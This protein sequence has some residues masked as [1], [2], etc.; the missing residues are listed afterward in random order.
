MKRARSQTR[1][2]GVPG[3]NLPTVL[4][5]FIGRE[6]EIAGATQLLA[7]ARLVTLTGAAGCGKSRLA[8]RLVAEVSHA[9]QDGVY[10]VGLARLTDPALVP[11]AIAKVLRVPEQPGRP[12]LAGLL[13]A[14][15]GRQLLLALD[16]CEHLLHASAQLVETLLAKTEVNILATS[17]EQ[18]GVMGERLYPVAPLSLPPPTIPADRVDDIGQFEAVRLFI[19]RARAIL[20]SFALTPDN[21]VAVA[22]I[23]RQLD[24]IP[25]AIELASARLNV[26]TAVQIA[27]RLEHLFELL[28]A[29]AHVAYSHHDT[30]HAAIGWSYDLL[31]APEQLLLLRLSVFAGGCSLT[32]AETVCAGDGVAREQVLDLLSSL[33]N[34]SLV[35]AETIQRGEARYALLETIRQYAQEKLLAVDEG[36]KIYDR[37]LQCFLRLTEEAEPKLSGQ[38][39]Q[40]WLNWLEGEYDNIRAALTWS[41]PSGRSQ[42]GRV[43]AGLRIATALYQFWTIRDYV[44][45]GLAWMERL[46]AQ[47]DEEL[48]AL[49]RA[50]ALAYAAFLAGFRGNRAAQIAYGREAAILA[51]AAGEKGKPALVWALTAQA[52]GARAEGDYETE[53]TIARRVIQLWRELGDRYYLGLALSIYSY[54]AMSLGHYGAARAMLDEAF[55]LLREAG[56][57]YR[58]AMA[59]NFSGDLARCQADYS[60]AQTAYEQSVTLLRELEAVR[61]LA[62]ALHNLGHTYLHLGDIERAHAL[63]E[64]C[65]TLQQVQQNKPGVAECLIGFAALA[66]VR[67]MPAAGARLLS[68]AVAIGGEAVAI[69]WP[70]TRLEYEYYLALARA[71]LTENAFQAEQVAGRTFSL[72]QAVAYAQEVARKTMVAQKAHQKV[73]A[74]TAR[75][76]E[77]AVLVTQGKSNGEIAAELV[78]SKRTVEKHI[79]N[80]LSKLW[81]TNRAQIV[82]WGIEAGLVN[83]NEPE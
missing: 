31:S 3:T 27:A 17:R 40:L 58:I 57:S 60:Q 53:F 5:P 35:A 65:L 68:A 77:V 37:H 23:C 59:L 55:P 82:R 24:G 19:E 2:V 75:E 44:Q 21:A 30:L 81:F 25:L 56:N 72:E 36:S 47:A 63:F 64:E 12:L 76:R 7:T 51:E 38:Y 39:Q 67:A 48:S 29:A 79:A 6:R 11:L 52:Y 13:D 9:Y 70:A 78:L 80:I 16:N 8:L 28:P 41:L 22:N 4:T 10:W 46:L 83:S 71:G 54:T 14:L 32:T 66:I 42:S 20:P 15:H 61:D 74:L 33:V 62:S 18:L 34:K 43:E 26:L 73:D 45:E 69:T 50:K 1:T 49:V